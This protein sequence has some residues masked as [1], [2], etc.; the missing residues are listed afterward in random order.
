[1]LTGKLWCASVVCLSFVECI[2]TGA[3]TQ[4]WEDPAIARVPPRLRRYAEHTPKLTAQQSGVVPGAKVQREEVTGQIRR[5]RGRVAVP[6]ARNAREAASLFL[7]A[8]ASR[9]GLEDDTVDLRILRVYESLT[10]HHVV[11]Q[12]VYAGMPVFGGQVAVHMDSKLVITLV[13]QD[14]MPI[15]NRAKLQRPVDPSAAISAAVNAVNP[16]APPSTEP[17]AEAG[18]LVDR[19]K[20]RSVWRVTFMTPSP[21]AAWLVMVDSSTNSVVWVENVAEHY[22]PALEAHR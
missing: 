19:G 8:N 7:R 16:V 15:L 10:G 13:N 17:R 14:L 1:M 18:V 3:Q 2:S 6:G 5:V 12:Q 9:L 22:R 20:A 11:Y 21:A 4:S